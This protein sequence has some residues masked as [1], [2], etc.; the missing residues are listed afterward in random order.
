MKGQKPSLIRCLDTLLNEVFI[1]D[2]ILFDEH[3]R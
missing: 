2:N 3:V 1:S